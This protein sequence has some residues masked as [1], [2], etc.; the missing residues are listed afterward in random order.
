MKPASLLVA[1]LCACYAA[2]QNA[3]V[4]LHSEQGWT[5]PGLSRLVTGTPDRVDTLEL[6]GLPV[7]ARIF[8]A[9]R[10]TAYQVLF[11]SPKDGV[12][13]VTWHWV[14]PKT[15][16]TYE[17]DGR[18]FAVLVD[19]VLQHTSGSPGEG[20]TGGEVRLLYQ[21]SDGE[22]KLKLLTEN[23]LSDYRPEIPAW[24]RK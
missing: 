18:R 10:A 20:G 22:G 12:N 4:R 19:G 6:D 14:L 9:R 15:V 21:D 1:L 11:L 16:T 7:R 5:I 23:I 3:P 13:Y 24:A 8:S 17:R 2:A